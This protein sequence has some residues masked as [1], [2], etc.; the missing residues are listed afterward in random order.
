[1]G[2]NVRLECSAVGSPTPQ[3]SWYKNDAQLRFD[4]RIRLSQDGTMLE[5]TSARE[6]DSALYICEARNPLGYR[7]VSANVEVTS[8]SKN[9][10]QLVY[11][12]YDIE[13]ILGG[14]IELPCKGRNFSKV[15]SWST[16]T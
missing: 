2:E 6:S 5:I 12:P 16:F 1:M 8:T 14:T 15:R 10:P 9:P 7:E 4:D 13:A 3:I 11:K